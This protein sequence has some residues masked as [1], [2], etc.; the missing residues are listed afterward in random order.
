MEFTTVLIMALLL[1]L[2][3][4]LDPDHIVAVTTIVSQ[5]KKARF[6]AL[7]G[8]WWGVGHMTTIV[9]IG[10]AIIYFN[11]LISHS[12]EKLLEGIVGAMIIYLGVKASYSLSTEKKQEHAADRDKNGWML[13]P[14]IVGLLH[15]LAGSTGVAYLFLSTIDDKYM[16]LL[17]LLVFGAG[18]L[19][20][21]VLAT[22]LIGM[23]YS[24]ASDHKRLNLLLTRSTGILSV[25]F[26][27]YYLCE[28]LFL[29]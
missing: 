24:W 22:I 2:K 29:S 17:Y 27:I 1:G 10:S 14:L 28:I 16:G 9:L 3:H 18:T 21:M 7:V 8:A 25:I 15:G 5:K 13:R 26:G 6:S 12:V 19:L 4:A 23:P 11:L 20:S